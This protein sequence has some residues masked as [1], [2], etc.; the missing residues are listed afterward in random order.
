M[1]QAVDRKSSSSSSGLSGESLV[2]TTHHPGILRPVQDR[3][4]PLVRFHV[5][6]QPL[7]QL[8]NLLHGFGTDLE[9]PPRLALAAVGRGNGALDGAPQD[10]V[11]DGRL[12]E[13]VHRAA[14]NEQRLELGGHLRRLLGNVIVP[15]QK[16]FDADFSVIVVVEVVKERFGF[17]RRGFNFELGEHDGEFVGTDGPGSVLVEFGKDL[18]GARVLLFGRGKCQLVGT[19]TGCG[20]G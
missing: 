20:C 16:V 7:F 5:F 4:A 1:A 15:G 13:V 3:T 10:V 11:V 19:A 6:L 12:V 2:V 14:S 9:E 17:F 18:L 8:G